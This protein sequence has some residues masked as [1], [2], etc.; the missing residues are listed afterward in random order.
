MQARRLEKTMVEKAGR[1]LRQVLEWPTKVELIQYLPATDP[2]N[3]SDE[4]TPQF[5]GREVGPLVSTCLPTLQGAFASADSV[6]IFQA[7]SI[8]S[9]LETALAGSHIIGSIHWFFCT[10]HTEQDPFDDPSI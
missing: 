6:N 9:K 7:V 1:R 2:P 5:V 10:E 8:D 4:L 3:N